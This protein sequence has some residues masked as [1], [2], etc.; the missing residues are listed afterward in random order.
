M[1]KGQI[2]VVCFFDDEGKDVW[3][4]IIIHLVYQKRTLKTIELMFLSYRG[5]S[6]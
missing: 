3:E 6:V 1:D 5:D 2:K 4:L